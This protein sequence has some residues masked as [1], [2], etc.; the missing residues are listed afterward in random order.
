[1]RLK[2]I[3]IYILLFALVSCA[4]KKEEWLRCYAQ[5]KCI[6]QTEEA[7]IKADSIE[8]IPSLISEK[9]KLQEQLSSVT[10]PFEKRISELNEGIKGAQSEYMKAYRIA[11]GKQSAKFGHRNTPAYEKEINELEN[12]KRTKISSLQHKIAEV[13]S[14]M[15]NNNE[16]RSITEKIKAQDNKIKT[17]QEAIITSHKAV[18]DSLQELLNVENSNF[19]RMISELEPSEQKVLESKRDSIRVNPCK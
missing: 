3:G 5:T 9:E 10:A 14:E 2:L 18:I 19:K 16:Y 8:Q 1:M 12:I 17:T 13:K 15:E 11:E 7:K 6:Y 4:D